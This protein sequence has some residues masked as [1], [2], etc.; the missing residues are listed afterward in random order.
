MK[1]LY[2][3]YDVCSQIRQDWEEEVRTD[4]GGKGKKCPG[5]YSIPANK[6]CGK[7]GKGGKMRSPG[8]GKL[9]RNLAIGAAGLAVAGGG[10]AAAA[11]KNRDKIVAGVDKVG[12]KIRSKAKQLSSEARGNIGKIET[13]SQEEEM[14]KQALQQ[15]VAAA[16][17]GVSRATGMASR[18]ARKV[19]TAAEGTVGGAKKR[20]SSVVDKA[21]ETF[22]NMTGGKERKKKR[23]A[24][25]RV[26]TGSTPTMKDIQ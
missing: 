24:V 6:Q 7:G 20:V 17:R 10:A 4:M 19:K 14:G 22:S 11:Y 15:Q 18:T 16:E 5:G 21:K 3:S 2:D 8:G 1:A 12:A 13:N 9:G 23:A 25:S 26:Q